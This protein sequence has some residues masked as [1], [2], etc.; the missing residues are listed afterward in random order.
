[1]LYD[2][3]VDVSQTGGMINSALPCDELFTAALQEPRTRGLCT[4]CDVA[5]MLTI[6]TSSP[7]PRRPLIGTHYQ[8]L[9]RNIGSSKMMIKSGKDRLATE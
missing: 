9:C 7:P 5:A 3:A 8:K 2:G 4:L 6:A 1:M